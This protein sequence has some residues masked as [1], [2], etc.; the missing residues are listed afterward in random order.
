M[1]Y[2]TIKIYSI[3]FTIIE[4][5]KSLEFNVDNRQ[6]T[7]LTGAI[8]MEKSPSRMN[9]HKKNILF[10]ILMKI[11]LDLLRVKSKI[12]EMIVLFKIFLLAKSNF[13]LG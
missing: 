2:G 4:K 8:E 3:T 5:K 13:F 12:K 10:K 1:I 11:P 7:E 9:C 6:N